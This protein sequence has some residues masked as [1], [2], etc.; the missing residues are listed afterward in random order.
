MARIGLLVAAFLAASPAVAQD[1]SVKAGVEKWRSGDSTAAVAIWQPFAAQGDADAQFN[2]GQAYKLGRG[3]PQDAG[4][5]RDYYRQAAIKGHLPA[6]ANLGILLFQA[7]EKPEAMRWLKA[8][9]DKGESRAQYVFGIATFNGDGTPRNLG[10]AYG[11]LLRAS[12]Q[13]LAQATS[14]L[15]NIGPGL[16]PVDRANGEA[17]SASLAAGQG[18]PQAFAMNRPPLPPSRNE[19]LRPPPGVTAPPVQTADAVAAVPK[20]AVAPAPKPAVVSPVPVAAAPKPV[21]AQPSVSTLAPKPAAPQT[22]AVAGPVAGPT[23]K[24][25][26]ETTSPAPRPEAVAAPPAA[27]VKA[28]PKPAPVVV[29]ESKP[30]AAEPK[31]APVEVKTVA[32][33]AAAPTITKTA[34]V[35]I[36]KPAVQKPT[37]VA[38]TAPAGWRV[39]LGAFSKRS[40]A[41]EAWAAIRREQKDAI[42]ASKPVFDADGPVVK[43]QLGPYPTKAAARDACA[44]L[45]FAGRACFVTGG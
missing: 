34:A 4:K 37:P 29:A 30:V 22:A 24:P 13:G 16:S 41:D 21:A 11:Y 38:T 5:A 6:Q 36:S 31:P 40:L 9:A 23:A 35:A 42:G 10:L 32:V 1:A 8:A 19:V 39:Q 17:V 25:A 26:V 18:V 15:G 3:V 7:G 28:E 14:A 12:A 43:L 2:M 33:P 44:K 45:A 20:P 27:A